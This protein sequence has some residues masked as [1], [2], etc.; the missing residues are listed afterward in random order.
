MLFWLSDASSRVLVIIQMLRERERERDLV[1]TKHLQDY[2]IYNISEFFLETESYELSWWL[3]VY[4][5][6][7]T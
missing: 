4:H 6:L 7:S 1:G 5:P 3:L 2:I